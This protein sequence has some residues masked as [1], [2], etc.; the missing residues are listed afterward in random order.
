MYARGGTQKSFIRRGSAPRS[1]PLPFYIPFWQKRHPFCI[2]FI[3]KSTPFIYL[4]NMTYTL[5]M[6]F[7]WYSHKFKIFKGLFKHLND[8]ISYPFIYLNLWNSYPSI[9]LKP[10]KGTII[11]SNPTP[12]A[13]MSQIMIATNTVMII[14]GDPR[15]VVTVCGRDEGKIVLPWQTAPGVLENWSK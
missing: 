12:R 6:A 11:G 9:Y 8:R 5:N 1:N 14:L 7:S 2:P 3:E 10:E 4:H 15:T 13:C